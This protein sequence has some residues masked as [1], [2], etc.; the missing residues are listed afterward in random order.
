MVTA[1]LTL[2]ALKQ[3]LVTL[4]SAPQA[5][6]AAKGFGKPNEYARVILVA[7][8]ANPLHHAE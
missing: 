4:A 7:G 5:S 2:S 1:E 3:V 6:G 8:A